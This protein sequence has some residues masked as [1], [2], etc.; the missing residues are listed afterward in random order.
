VHTNILFQ[1]SV[2]IVV[3]TLFAIVARWTKQ[4]VILGYI[5]AGVVLG[6]TEGLGWITTSE[7][8]PISELGLILLLFMIGL[9]IDLKKL[10]RAG[11][12]MLAAGGGQFLICVVLGLLVMPMLGFK[13]SARGY[14]PLYLAVAAAL[15]STMI[16]VKLL[17]DKSEL[18]TVPGRLT[19][20]VLVFQDIWAILFLAVQP[21]LQNPAPIV[22]FSSLVKAA[23]MVAFT[24]AASRYVLPVL[25]RSI[26]K[27]PELLVLGA[28]AWCFFVALIAERLGLSLEM[29]ALIAGVSLSTFPYNMD[30]MAKVTSLR[31]FFITLFFVSLGSKIP[32]PTMQMTLLA[33]ALSG[34]LVASRFLSI[35]PI[36]YFLKQGNRASVVP[37]INLSQI[38]EFSLVI[39]TM[40]VGLGHISPRVLA[41]VVLALVITSV[42]STYAIMF[43]YEIFTWMNP[44]LRRLGMRDLGEEQP[45]DAEEG[46]IEPK[47]IVFVGF[48]RHGSSLLHELLVRDAAHA[49][50][51]G[52][53]DFNPRVKEELDRRGIQNVYGDISHLDTLHH[54]EVAEAKVLL[55]TIPDGLLKGTSNMRLLKLLKSLAPE[56]SVVVTAELFEEAD[57]MYTEGAAFVF[58]PRLMG[59]GELADA[60]DAALRGEVTEH[61][62]AARE[63]LMVREEVLP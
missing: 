28:L 17:Y 32:A 34:F 55:C 54:A 37:A 63:R 23:G 4:P 22:I 61:T 10:K 8:E 14:A 13:Y 9:E 11:K 39:C 56:A 27:V 20:G 24:L 25:F 40:G 26:A 50:D 29:G 7:I 44:F 49:K 3:A 5:A 38:S 2:A 12:P 15:S 6:Q 62:R 57:E 58:M 51:V 41:V 31:D 46:H 19:L 30:V 53:V 59:V 52:V 18:D 21:D 33:L 47:P 42:T 36:L 60:V 1:I 43:N 16:V 35:T 45:A 48:A